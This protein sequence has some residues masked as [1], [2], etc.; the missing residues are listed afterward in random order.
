MHLVAVAV[1]AQ[2]TYAAF[3]SAVDFYSEYPTE[4]NYALFVD[5]MNSF[6]IAYTE[7][8]TTYRRFII[9]VQQYYAEI[10]LDTNSA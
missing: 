7:L 10:G 8:S 3:K 6:T 4:S 1:A 2:Q 9:E 5:A